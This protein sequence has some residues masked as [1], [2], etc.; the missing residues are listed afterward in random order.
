M[1][2]FAYSFD[3]ET[4]HG[5][6]HTRDVALAA[7]KKALRDREDMPEG[8]F[9]GQWSEPDPQTAGHAEAIIAAMQ[10][11]ARQANGDADYLDGVTDQQTAALNEAVNATL[12]DWLRRTGLTPQ[13]TRVVAVSHHPVPT[14]EHVKVPHGERETSLIGE[15]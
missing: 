6:Y 13:A 11:R 7:A 9:V 1:T 10:D 3:Q 12:T 2:A 5:R 8:I 14:I 15:S 4:F